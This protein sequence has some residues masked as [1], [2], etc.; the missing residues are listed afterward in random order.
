VVIFSPK[1]PVLPRFLAGDQDQRGNKRSGDEM[2]S[3]LA[4]IFVV[5]VALALVVAAIVIGPHFVSGKSETTAAPQLTTVAVR[6]FPVTA[7]AAGAVVPSSE[8]AA[9][10]SG[11]GRLS[12]I[13]VHVGQQVTVGEALAQLDSTVAQSAVTQ[14]QAA[15]QGAQASLAAAQDPLDPGH[16]AVL[17]ASLTAAEQ[18]EAETTT[19]VQATN[20]QDQTALATAKQQLSADQQRQVNDDCANPATPNAPTPSATVCQTDQAAVTADQNQIE[21]DEARISSDSASGQARISQAASQVTQAQTALSSASAPV[22]SQVAAAQAAV[23]S[24]TAQLTSAQ[25]ALQNLTLVA[26]AAGTVLQINGQIGENVSGAATGAPTLPGTSAPIPDLPGYSSGSQAQPLIVLGNP[27]SYVVGAAFASTDIQALRP[28]QTGTIT[29]ST[30]S[31]LSIPC[32][33][34]AVA[35]TATTISGNPEYFVSLDPIGSTEGLT[36]GMSVDV[37]LNISQANRVLAVPQSAVYPLAGVPH[38]DVWDG[39]H[40]V[41]TQVATGAE[42]TQLVQITSGLTAGQQVVLSAYQ[43]LSSTLTPTQTAP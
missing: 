39:R 38:V 5:G 13:D 26:P 8:V 3:R 17:Q 23:A 41:A 11:S 40:A 16:A 28:G 37:T 15:L 7:S 21:Q 30:V 34:I 33:V 14:A 31:G 35:A 4:R 2:T 32:R 18:E 22:P 9:N 25:A 6:S 43:G 1:R 27:S 20:T 29:A 36:S 12:A 42:G 10:F 24:A 19:E